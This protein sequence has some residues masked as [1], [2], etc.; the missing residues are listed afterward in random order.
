MH[1]QSGSAH[2]AIG[3]MA[4]TLGALVASCHPAKRTTSAPVPATLP[5]APP[6]MAA[7]KA[8][9]AL[10]DTARKPLPE[11]W[12][13]ST[14]HNTA[15]APRAMVASN[16]ALASGAGLE[17]LRAGG[18]AIDAA[19]A[20]GFALAV[21]HP[22]AGNLGGGGYMLIRLNDGR[23]FALDYREVAPLASTR[24]MFVDSRGH[25]TD[26]SQIGHLASGVPGSVAG[27]T[28]ALARYGTM[29]LDKVMAPAI[30]LADS[31]FV[32]DSAFAESIQGNSERIAPF[33]GA[34]LFMP[35]GHAPAIGSLFRQPALAH[36]LRAIADEWGAGVLR[37]ADRRRDRGGDEARRRHHHEGGPGALRSGVARPAH[38]HL[39]RL[40]AA[41]DAALVVRRNHDAG[42]AQHPRAVPR[43]ACGEREELPLAR[44]GVSARVHRPQH[45]ARRSR[46]RAGAR[47]RAHEQGLRAQ[48]RGDDRPRAR[49]ENRRVPH[50]ED[51]GREHHALLGGRRKRQLRGDDDHAERSVWLRCVRRRRADFS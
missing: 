51:R 45:E 17:I 9:Q 19:V 37:G 39:S 44:R 41:R 34:A 7:V 47:G 3:V 29:P 27:M 46:V 43:V 50:R 48:P 49:D 36:T 11:A 10:A 28:A 15:V 24:D 42:D 5:N 22:E 2:R 12:P 20:M 33:A 21:T 26:R 30:R 16:S 13:L 38:G 32:V 31:G 6:S 1:L 23:S 8:A 14:I 18:N 40:F 25:V 4:V 35:H